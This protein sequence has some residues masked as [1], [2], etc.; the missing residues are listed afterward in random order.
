VH[1]G[2][3]GA[4]AR[5]RLGRRARASRVLSFFDTEAGRYVQVRRDEP[6]EQA[7]TT[8]SPADQRRM[9][10]HISSLLGEVAQS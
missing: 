6:G 2:Q 3:I 1:Q 8:I 9:S 7:W 10:Q 5:D 4:A